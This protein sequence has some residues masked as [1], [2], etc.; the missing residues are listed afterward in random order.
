[1]RIAS[2]A[3]AVP[4]RYYKQEELTEALMSDWA[5]RLS[6]PGILDRFDASMQVEGRY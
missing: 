3:I 1:M 5:H 4:E 2:V 6:N